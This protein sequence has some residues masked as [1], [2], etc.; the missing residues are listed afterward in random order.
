[1]GIDAC[2][3]VL[4]SSNHAQCQAASCNMENALRHAHQGP[5][6]QTCCAT[7]CMQM[8]MEMLL[9]G[10]AQTSTICMRPC[11]LIMTNTMSLT[12]KPCLHERRETLLPSKSLLHC[13]SPATLS[14]IS[15]GSPSLAGMM[16]SACM[17]EQTHGMMA[18]N[19]QHGQ[20]TSAKSSN[21]GHL[22]CPLPQGFCMVP[23]SPHTHP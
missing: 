19:L 4:H 3:G 5:H 15:L 10:Q 12:F 18:G 23:C 6:A 20:Q 2:H 7:F 11:W 14:G 9:A 13:S 17:L 16:H 1:M 22:R 21:V 8:K